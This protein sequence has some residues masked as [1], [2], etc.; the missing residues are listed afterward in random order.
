MKSPKS[1][2]PDRNR[3]S[4]IGKDVKR[5]SYRKDTTKHKGDTPESRLL[6]GMAAT[7]DYI[8]KVVKRRTKPEAG[9]TS[10]WQEDASRAPAKIGQHS[11]PEPLHDASFDA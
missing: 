8:G 2:S 1:K 10:E 11:D 3:N 4:Y 6:T 7:L 5:R 9:R